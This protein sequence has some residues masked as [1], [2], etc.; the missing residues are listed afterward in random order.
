MIK[1]LFSKTSLIIKYILFFFL[2]FI[3]IESISRGFI[4][5]VTKDLK[6]FSYGFNKDIKIDIFHLRKLNIKLTDLYLVNPVL[7]NSSIFLS[8]SQED[9]FI[10]STI[11]LLTIETVNSLVSFIFNKVSLG[12]P[13]LPLNAGEKPIIGGFAPNALK[14]ENG[15]RLDAPFLSREPTKA[16]G[17]GDTPEINR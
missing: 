5:I 17:R 9:R 15:A 1:Y 11:E 14:N 4:W 2:F 7:I 12:S 10:C 3:I 16:I 13:V 6:T 8:N